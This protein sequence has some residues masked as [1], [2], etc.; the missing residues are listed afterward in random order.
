MSIRNLVN[1]IVQEKRKE[2][3]KEK[4]KEILI[5]VVKDMVNVLKDTVVVSM[6][7]VERVK[8]TVM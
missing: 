3:L 2:K 4:L 7:G 6:V 1:V 8:N 5:N